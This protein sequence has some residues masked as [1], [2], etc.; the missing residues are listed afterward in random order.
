MDDLPDDCITEII[1]H[2]NYVNPYSYHTMLFQS[3][4]WH[5]LILAKRRPIVNYR[6]MRA[7][8]KR[9]DYLSLAVSQYCYSHDDYRWILLMAEA[10][11]QD[12]IELVLYL[13]NK[14]KRPD[15]P[16]K[17]AYKAYKAGNNKV[18]SFMEDYISRHKIEINLPYFKAMAACATGDVA[19]VDSYLKTCDIRDRSLD[20]TPFGPGQ[21]LTYKA[22]KYN[23][24]DVLKTIA[25]YRYVP[26]AVVASCTA[27]GGHRQRFL[28]LIPEIKR[29]DN[30][31]K[32]Y[33]TSPSSIFECCLTCSGHMDIID[34]ISEVF[35]ID[36]DTWYIMGREAFVRGNVKIMK[37]CLDKALVTDYEQMFITDLTWKIDLPTIKA[38]L[39]DYVKDVRPYKQWLEQMRYQA[40][41]WNYLDIV[42]YLSELIQ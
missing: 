42:D 27:I 22:A 35:S 13:I 31:H 41:V 5:R 40:T 32:F 9:C 36:Q 18:I 23:Q 37:R 17:F 4:Q 34:D 28:E 10:A 30:P 21:G 39:S 3:K 29:G 20:D 25:K 38:L 33:I 16:Y 12:Y 19:V 8:V 6:E 26:I 11:E 1:S 24:T 14:Q 7:A 2:F 15:L